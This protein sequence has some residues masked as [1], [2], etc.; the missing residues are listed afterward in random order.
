MQS[1]REQQC[2][3]AKSS[4]VGGYAMCWSF[5]HSAVETGRLRPQPCASPAA[6]LRAPCEEP[7]SQTASSASRPPSPPRPSALCTQCRRSPSS[8]EPVAIEGC[9]V[10]GHVHVNVFAEV[11]V[12][13]V[14]TPLAAQCVAVP[15]ATVGVASARPE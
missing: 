1:Q 10:L 5:P 9:S 14:A 8:C 3:V 12:M 4:D 6:I 7:A 2:L 13:R 11:V 15:S